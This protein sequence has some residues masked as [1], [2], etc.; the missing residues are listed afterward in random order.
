[1]KNMFIQIIQGFFFGVANIIP[2][3]SGGT[4]ALILGFYDRL[5]HLLT[6]LKP[7]L[8]S[9][10]ISAWKEEKSNGLWKLFV[11][12]D[13][14]FGVLLGVGLLI[15]VVALSPLMKY[16]LKNEFSPTY[17]FFFGLILMSVWVPAK[18]VKKW[19]LKT[20][21]SFIVGVGLTIG[22]AANV[23]P[24]D[25]VLAK[26]AQLESSY[27]ESSR[28]EVKSFSYIGKYT[29]GELTQVAISGAVGVSAM[30]LPGVS[31]SLVLILLGQYE[32]VLTAIAGMKKLLLD[33]ALFL[34]I[35]AFGMLQC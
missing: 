10:F 35:F 25:K 15:A 22:V 27:S 6:T 26:S 8:L 23:N 2:G 17:A 34:G 33:D 9:E 32:G 5:I 7:A 28:Q 21:L 20:A 4:L 29:V 1:M 18:L 14:F 16:L 3:V 24:A 12:K 19:N 30:L 11:K 31:G 13:F